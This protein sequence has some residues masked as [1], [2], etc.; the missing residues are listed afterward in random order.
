MEYQ[1]EKLTEALVLARTRA[2]DLES[3]TKLNFWGSDIDNVSVVRKMPNLEVCSLSVNSIKTL[4][5]FSYCPN[6][7]ELYIRKNKIED[8]SEINH[9]ATL[10][11]LRN[12][13]LADNPCAETENYRSN[14][15][16]TLPTLQKLDNIVVTESERSEFAD[17]ELLENNTEDPDPETTGAGI[18]GIEDS[19]SDLTEIKDDR[20]PETSF[21]D[22]DPELAGNSRHMN[23]NGDREAEKSPDESE[24]EV[25]AETE[26]KDETEVKTETE[27]KSE[28]KDNDPKPHKSAALDPVTLTWEETNKIRQEVGLKPLPYEK[29]TSTRPVPGSAMT[30][31]NAHVLQAVLILIRELDDDSLETIQYAIQRKLNPPS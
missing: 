14:V 11:R 13:W 31:R 30:S 1:E 9:L 15:L 20:E 2:I 8:L 23:L 29:I 27:E 25:K 22:K 18:A 3:V 17:T 21:V 6:L 26:V 28:V 10:P 16:K 7:Q 4:E 12:L 19:S 24:T 5:D